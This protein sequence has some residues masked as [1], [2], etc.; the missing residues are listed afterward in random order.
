M[1]N[2]TINDDFIPLKFGFHFQVEVKAM[3]RVKGARKN[4]FLGSFTAVVEFT[5]NGGVGSNR[6]KTFI[7]TLIEK[8]VK[9]AV[10]Y[11]Q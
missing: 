8:A 2:T 10:S 1:Y 11:I 6:T 4:M 3:G 9:D 5:P 7:D